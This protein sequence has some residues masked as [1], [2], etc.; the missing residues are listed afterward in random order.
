LAQIDVKLQRAKQEGDYYKVV[1]SLDETDLRDL[2]HRNSGHM[3]P[4]LTE[5]MKIQ[6]EYH[7]GEPQRQIA[8]KV[9]CSQA[10]VHRYLKSNSA[11]RDEH[12]PHHPGRGKLFELAD[13]YALA[14]FFFLNSCATRV[15]GVQFAKEHLNI[16]CSKKT[17]SKIIRKR[18]GFRILDFVVKYPRQRNKPDIKLQRREFFRDIV[19]VYN[20][21][22]GSGAASSFF[23]DALYFDEMKLSYTNRKKGYT[24][25]GWVPSDWVPGEKV[26]Y[27][28]L[29]VVSPQYGVI[30][31]ILVKNEGV[32]GNHIYHFM[33]QMLPKFFEKYPWKNR[34]QPVPLI[35]DNARSQETFEAD[36]PAALLSIFER[37]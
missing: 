17:V 16:N 32:T 15:D 6:I 25:K 26:R 18:C 11:F 4:P 30:Y 28:L 2:H 31:Y 20:S 36:I 21:R 5:E 34:N 14:R 13:E 1:K 23:M 8:L 3:N 37:M 22:C 7:R 9:G 10:S 33:Q 24:L 35:L 19:K 27:S 29:L 12:K